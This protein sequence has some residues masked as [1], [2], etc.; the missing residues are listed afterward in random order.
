MTREE[1][2]A[3]HRAY[4]NRAAVIAADTAVAKLPGTTTIDEQACVWIAAY[5]AVANREVER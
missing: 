2:Q 3:F 4:P 1:N 5:E